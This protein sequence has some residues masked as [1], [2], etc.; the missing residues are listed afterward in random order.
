MKN[1][2]EADAVKRAK[3]MAAVLYM[4]VLTFVVGGTYINQ[5]MTADNV[6]VPSSQQ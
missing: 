2:S 5:Q 4:L 1:R 6:E 3:N